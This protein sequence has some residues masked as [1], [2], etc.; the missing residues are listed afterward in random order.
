M[1]YR[2]AHH[3]LF[4]TAKLKRGHLFLYRAHRETREI[5][6]LRLNLPQN[7]YFLVKVKPPPKALIPAVNR[8]VFARR[9][10]EKTPEGLGARPAFII[11]NEK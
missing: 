6:W 5:L 4:A 1:P 3:K 9:N 8:W 7:Y 10:K 11:F 2:I